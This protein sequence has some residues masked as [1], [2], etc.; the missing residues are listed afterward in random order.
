VSSDAV[1]KAFGDRIRSTWEREVDAVLPEIELFAGP[2]TCWMPFAT[3][4]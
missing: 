4:G 3:A 2:Q 1:E